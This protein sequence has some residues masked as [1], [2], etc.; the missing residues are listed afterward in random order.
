MEICDINLYPPTPKL[1]T[2]LNENTQLKKSND[3]LVYV[4][5]GGL[6]IGVAML[7]IHHKENEDMKKIKFIKA[8]E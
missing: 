7:V 6:I 3:I 1:S 2:I 5:I 8:E 4:V